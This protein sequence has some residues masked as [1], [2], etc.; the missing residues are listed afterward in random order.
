VF[1]SLNVSPFKLNVLKNITIIIIII[2]IMY[3]DELD[4]T[5]SERRRTIEGCD[6]GKNGGE[7]NTRKKKNRYD[8]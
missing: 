7:E 8:Q 1:T 5:Y 3:L 4:W 6:R 2:G